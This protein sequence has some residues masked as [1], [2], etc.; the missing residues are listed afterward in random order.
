MIAAAT[1]ART[2]LDDEKSELNFPFPRRQRRAIGGCELFA[3][4]YVFII[5]SGI[6]AYIIFLRENVTD[7]A[8]VY[9][10]QTHRKYSIRI[11]KKICTYTTS[12]TNIVNR[13]TRISVVTV[14]S[15]VV[16]VTDIRYGAYYYSGA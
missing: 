4:Y 7:E 6:G 15:S 8:S 16:F 3:Y 2:L 10:F 5:V 14:R 12:S 1:A 9:E 11:K 13:R